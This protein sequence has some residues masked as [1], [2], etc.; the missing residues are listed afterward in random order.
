MNA[1]HV[2]PIEMQAGIATAN[3]KD[4]VVGVGEGIWPVM[5]DAADDFVAAYKAQDAANVRAR[6]NAA[7]NAGAERAARRAKAAELIASIGA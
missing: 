6:A 4:G 3:V 1:A 5:V 2:Y 7:L